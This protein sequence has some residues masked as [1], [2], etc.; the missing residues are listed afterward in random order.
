MPAPYRSSQSCTVARRRYSHLTGDR[1]TSTARSDGRED[2]YEP[3][4]T[5]RLARVVGEFAG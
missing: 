4:D 5:A 3:Q 2:R 1:H